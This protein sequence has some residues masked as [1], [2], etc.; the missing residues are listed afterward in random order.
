MVNNVQARETVTEWTLTLDDD[1]MAAVTVL[2]GRSSERGRVV[3][4]VCD[5][6]TSRKVHLLYTQ[7]MR[8]RGH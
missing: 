7:I 6:D 1:T 8:Q 4:K 2:I 3:D 5:G